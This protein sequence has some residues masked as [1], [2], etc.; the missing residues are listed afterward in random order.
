M[1]TRS[2][3]KIKINSTLFYLAYLTQRWFAVRVGLAMALIVLL[4]ACLFLVVKTSFSISWFIGSI[5][6]GHGH[7]VNC[8]T[9]GTEKLYRV[10]DL[11]S[12]IGASC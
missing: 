5:V 3:H 10:R 9:M 12:F 11:C 6:V 4:L 1:S 7:C 2:Q 8:N